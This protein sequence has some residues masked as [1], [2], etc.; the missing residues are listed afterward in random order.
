MPGYRFPRAD[1]LRVERPVRNVDAVH[2][3]DE[4]ASLERTRRE[5]LARVPAANL[6]AYLGFRDLEGQQALR[7]DGRL[8]FLVVDERRR[9]AE[10]AVLAD[11]LGIED[12]DSLAALTLDRA[13]LGGPSTLLRG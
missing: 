5:P 7:S 1:G 8:D 13:P 6:L 3:I 10:L 2:A 4:G 9:A 11:A 12:R